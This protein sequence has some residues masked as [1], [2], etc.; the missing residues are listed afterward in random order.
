MTGAPLDD[1]TVAAAWDGNAPQ[2]ADDVRAG[3]DL[4]REL[5][6][7]PAFLDFLPPIRG[8]DVIDLG[9]GEGSNTRSFAQLG[10]HVT[11][12]DLS[13]A[14]IELARRREAE[15][16]LG[17]LYEVGS[18]GDLASF[19]DQ[20]Y[21]GALSTMALMDGPDLRAAFAAAY[22]V[23]KPSGLL[24]FTMLHPCFITPAL[25]WLYDTDRAC[26]GLRI[27]RYFDQAPFVERW[28]FKGRSGE[29]SVPPFEV[30]RFPRTLSDYV[31]ALSDAGFRIAKLAEPR[32]D[33]AWAARHAWLDRW[34]RHAPLVLMA[35]AVRQ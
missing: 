18:F 33:P 7:L 26:S 1:A 13:P 5:Y 29:H 14:M 35:A 34:R 17:I 23:L 21:D 9:C 27:G 19:P 22:R 31:N 4:Y 25:K 15:D 24:C 10:A 12:V 3:L 32:P 30:P 11:G 8:L 28:R 16:P 6:T 20:G 2:W